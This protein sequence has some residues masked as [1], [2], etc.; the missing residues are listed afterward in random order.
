MTP[1]NRPHEGITDAARG[2]QAGDRVDAACRN[3][4]DAECALHTAHQSHVDSWIA[5]AGERLHEAIA[6]HLF[7]ARA[8]RTNA[9]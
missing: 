9:R 3:L 6:E 1:A 7:A 8:A 2:P 4:Y 5:A